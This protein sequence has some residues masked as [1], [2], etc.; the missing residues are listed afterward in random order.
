M[1]FRTLR[2]R[3]FQI[4]NTEFHVLTPA[5][6]T[7]NINAEIRD[8][9]DRIQEIDN[10][11]IENLITKIEAVSENLT[12]CLDNLIIEITQ[13]EINSMK[14]HPFDDEE[15]IRALIRVNALKDS[16]QKVNQELDYYKNQLSSLNKE[17]SNYIRD[18]IAQ[19]R[20]RLKFN[21]SIKVVIALLKVLVDADIITIASNV[22]LCHFVAQ[23]F[24][25]AGKNE[26]YSITSLQKSMSPEL[27]TIKKLEKTIEVIKKKVVTLRKDLEFQ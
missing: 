19:G 17:I 9:Y 12:N 1:N 2:H 4:T 25:S 14:A 20:N 26:D 5:Q 16:E 18:N 3:L 24:S 23:N 8:F 11:Q 6:Y 7:L 15:N 21:L 13:D 10:E 22:E 27:G